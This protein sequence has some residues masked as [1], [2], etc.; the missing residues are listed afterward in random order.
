VLFRSQNADGSFTGGMAGGTGGGSGSDGGVGMLGSDG[1]ARFDFLTDDSPYAGLIIAE[2]GPFP[3]V[4]DRSF[5]WFEG[6]TLS[7]VASSILGA[8]LHEFSHGFGLPH[9]AR[10]DENF[11]GNLLGNGLRGIRGYFYPDR[12]P[13]DY[14]RLS[15]PSAIA[16]NVSRYFN[17]DATFTDNTRPVLSVLTTGAVPLTNGQLRIGF[18]ATDAGGL[19][20]ATLGDEGGILEAMP[21]S[22]TSTNGAFLTPIFTPGQSNHFFIFVYDRQ[23]NRQQAETFIVP[24]TGANRAP[25]PFLKILPPTPAAGQAVTLSAENSTDPDHNRSQVQVEWDVDGDGQFDTSPT[26]TKTLITNFTTAGVRLIRA[27]LTDPA[28]AAALAVPLGLRV[29]VPDAAAATLAVTPP[30]DPAYTLTNTTVLAGSASD[31][32]GVL[33]VTV[34][35]QL[36]ATTNAFTHWSCGLG[37]L[38]IGTNEITIVACDKAAPPNLHT[39]LHRIVYAAGEFDGDADGLPDAWELS[40]LGAVD[41]PDGGANADPDGDGLTN[42]QEYHSG[43]DPRNAASVLRVEALIGSGSE[44]R[45]SFRTVPGKHYCIEGKSALTTDMW[46]VLV[47]NLAGDGSVIDW[48]DPMTPTAAQRFYRLRLGR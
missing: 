33:W 35:G 21:L 20:A 11:H 5:P 15:Y 34:N 32:S 26:T 43:T 7:S 45:L 46:T 40:C 1:L 24:A 41:A 30:I 48:V 39:N 37:P 44:L 36:V 38:A 17:A 3:L 8:A 22:G 16:L 25:Q 47:T 13:N 27:R 31:T 12:Y 4:Q 14:T 10:N 29:I 28:A 6:N 42:A 9:T 23:G 2:L 19:A 18:Y